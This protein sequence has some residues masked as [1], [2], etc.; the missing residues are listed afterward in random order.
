MIIVDASLAA[1]W[2]LWEAQSEEAL[3][4]WDRHAGD[5]GAPDLMAIEVASAI[6]RRANIDKALTAAMQE[7][8][9]QWA[10]M[11]AG[12]QLQQFRTTPGRVL[13]SAHLALGMGHPVK[14]CLYLD[15]AMELDCPLLTCDLKF[16]EKAKH[17]HPDVKVFGRV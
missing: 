1:K 17:M 3:D 4:L 16:A 7:G 14:D 15:L 10:R 5:L 12:T 8:L 2:I 6:V 11:M 9:R 13:R